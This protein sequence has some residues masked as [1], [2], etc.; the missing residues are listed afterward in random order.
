[1]AG[2]GE[3][4]AYTRTGEL[5][6]VVAVGQ[7]PARIAVS[8]DGRVPVVANRQGGSVSVLDPAP[9]EEVPRVDLAGSAFP[10]GAALDPPAS[11]PM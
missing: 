9:L 5:E 1:M 11:A 8:G 6:G 7:G 3:V 10:H 2:T 4:R